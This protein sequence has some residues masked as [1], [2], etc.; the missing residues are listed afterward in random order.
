MKR[1][2]AA[3]CGLVFAATLAG[4]GSTTDSLNFKV[5]TGY[6]NKMNTFIMSLWQKGDA[7]T[8]GFIMLMKLPVKVDNSKFDAST[9]S[10]SGAKNMKIESTQSIQICGNQPAMLAKATGTSDQVKGKDM[11]MEMLMTGVGG[12]SYIAMYMYPQKSTPDPDAEAAIKS[13]C[14]KSAT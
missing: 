14:A 12:N 7:D 2:F 9:F 6:T 5:P 10:S 11:N 13:V 8:G 1:L 4:C 3:A